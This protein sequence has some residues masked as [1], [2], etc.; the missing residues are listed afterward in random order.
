MMAVKI[1][2]TE[3][4]PGVFYS[5]VRYL[6]GAVQFDLGERKCLLCSAFVVFSVPQ[7]S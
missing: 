1:I 2:W 4:C 5:T 6:L 3:S 7:S